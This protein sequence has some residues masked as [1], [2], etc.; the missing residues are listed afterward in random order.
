MLL[1]TKKDD[2]VQRVLKKLSSDDVV[3][4]DMPVG[5]NLA[6]LIFIDPV[7]NKEWLGNLA[8]K[9]LKAFVGKGDFNDV[10]SALGSGEIKECTTVEEITE[11]IILGNPALIIEDCNKALTFGAKLIETRAISEPPTSTVL[12]GPR[13]G[14]TE[15]IIASL[16]LMRQRIKSE[17]MK[18]KYFKVGKYSQTLVVVTYVEGITP[19]ELI[20]QIT[21]RIK[22]IDTD[23]ILDSSYIAQHLTKRKASIFKQ[24]GTTEKPDVLVSKILEGRVG[25]LVEGSPIALTLPY[26]MLE[27]FQSPADYYTLNYRAVFSRLIRLIAVGIAVLLPSFYVAAELFHIQLIPLKFLLTIVNGIKGIPLSPSIEMFFTLLIFEILFEA[28]VRMPKHAGMV[29]S[30]VGGL[31]LGETAVSAGIISAPTLMIMALSGICLFT[32]P[33]LQETFSIIRLIYLLVAGAL[34][35]YALVLLTVGLVIYLVDFENFKTPI[36]APYAPLIESDLK[37]GFFKDFNLSNNTRPKLLRSKN[38]TRQIIKDR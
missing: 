23:A 14:F 6:T 28:S 22:L 38:R 8:L 31:V 36:L 19:K 30:I 3:T 12:K 27:D 15:N 35:G 10:K 2:N 4:L 1:S 26:V 29:I 5:D 21:D 16:N 13:T 33:E 17:K 18:F 24:Y 32:A 34:G 9:P 37:D 20:K 11:Q 7:T 25:I